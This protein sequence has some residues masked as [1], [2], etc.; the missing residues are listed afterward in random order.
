MRCLYLIPN[1]VLPRTDH[2]DP[3]GEERYNATLP[4]ASALHGGGRSTPRLG[5][6]TLGK[7]PGAHCI[8]GPHRDSI[9]IQ[10]FLEIQ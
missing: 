5:R 10:K 6:F 7:G 9:P 2:E 8:G 3:D 1:K 4:L